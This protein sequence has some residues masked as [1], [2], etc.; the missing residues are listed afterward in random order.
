[1]L[2][3][4]NGPQAGQTRYLSP[5]APVTIGRH[6]SRELPLD[7][8]KA[9]R[10]HARVAFRADCWHIED[11]GSR[12]GTYVNS[13]PVQQA[14][15]EPGDLIRIG[16]RLILFAQRMTEGGSALDRPS[17]LR[18][19]TIYEK[20]DPS[21]V[22]RLIR[23]QSV[24]D[25]MTRVVRDSAV[26]CRLAHSLHSQNDV[27]SLVRAVLDALVDGL[28]T[29]SVAVWLVGPDG[30]LRCAGRR[31]EKYDEHILASL[32]V[33]KRKA[34][35]LDDEAAP[36][37]ANKARQAGTAIGVPI[38]ARQA[39]LGAIECHRAERQPPF[40]RADLD[41]A[42]VV[43]HQM[44]AA[45]ENLEH[46]ER[47]EQ[48]NVELR[49][50]LDEQNRL[51]GS[52]PAMQKVLDQ[53]ARVGPTTANVLILG[54]SGTGKELI[55]RAIH[56]LSPYH[57]GPYVTVNCAAFSESLLES[58][59]FGHEPGAFTG[60]DRRHIG[61]FERAHRG[62]LF[63]DEVAEMSLACQAKLL[64]ILEGHPF[65]RLGGSESIR[66]EVRLIAAT[67]RDLRQLVAER[68]FREDLYYR[69]RV[70]DIHVPPLRERGDD[71]VELASVFLEQF[72]KQIGRGPRRFSAAAL[73]AIRDYPWPGNVREL[74]NAVERAVVLGAS[75]EVTPADL[76]LNRPDIAHSA[77]A[78]LV[79]LR[80]AEHRHIRYVLEQV[81]GNKS[82]ACR[83]LGIGRATLYSKL[84]EMGEAVEEE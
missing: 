58:E 14:V 56:D 70:V 41:F 35:C 3:V 51:I 6:P 39:C 42:V 24:A 5:D 69:L 25:A 59:L 34:I 79:S 57:A 61:Q 18:A 65:Q 82:Q 16:D 22:S 63:L 81:G 15:L 10:L 9:S 32:A 2:I 26:L 8:D 12:N 76:G 29:E 4:L 73:R 21:Q 40:S 50:R 77:G 55:A 49:R 62:T 36:N 19:T 60:A 11:C 45:L 17:K 64:R 80:E 46:R 52:S 33:E 44:G 31:G 47:L 53:I 20:G 67:H 75:D 78:G 13:Q 37:R 72:R 38:P 84:A 71:V 66:V 74:K 7:D 43:A 68:R 30:R 28:E 54:E 1:M 23:E 48:A 27:S 83:I